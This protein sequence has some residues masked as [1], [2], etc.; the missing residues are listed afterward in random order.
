MVKVHFNKEKITITLFIFILISGIIGDKSYAGIFDS[1]AD[2]PGRKM[3]EVWTKNNKENI[4]LDITSMDRNGESYSKSYVFFKGK[5]HNRT[6]SK[7]TSAYINLIVKNKQTGAIALTKKIKINLNVFPSGTQDI[8][9]EPFG[10]GTNTD[11]SYCSDI[12]EA[13]EQLGDNSSW[14]YDLLYF[15]SE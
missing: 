9:G 10:N 14:Y 8:T 7:I 3:A 2:F 6:S 4:D 11:C 1:I 15:E 12:F 13:I 5:I